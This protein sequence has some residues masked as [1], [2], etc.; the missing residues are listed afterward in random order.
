MGIGEL[1][2][3]GFLLMAAFGAMSFALHVRLPQQALGLAEEHGRYAGLGTVRVLTTRSA[4]NSSV[5]QAA[6]LQGQS[7]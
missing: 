3:I 1:M 4:R 6:S 2:A 5:L 7:A